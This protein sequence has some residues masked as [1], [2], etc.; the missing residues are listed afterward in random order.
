MLVCRYLALVAWLCALT[1]SFVAAIMLPIADIEGHLQQGPH[2][3]LDFSAACLF[4]LTTDPAI[5]LTWLSSLFLP[6]SDVFAIGDPN[7]S[8]FLAVSIA[9]GIVLLVFLVTCF[10]VSGRYGHIFTCFHKNR[11]RRVPRRNREICLLEVARIGTASRTFHTSQESADGAG[12]G[13]L[14][15]ATTPEKSVKNELKGDKND[16]ILEERTFFSVL[17]ECVSTFNQDGSVA[18]LLGSCNNTTETGSKLMINSQVLAPNHITGE[19]NDSSHVFMPR[20]GRNYPRT[21]AGS[22]TRYCSVSLGRPLRDQR[23]ACRSRDST[24]DIYAP[25]PS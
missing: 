12:Y 9:G 22:A 20:I 24:V 5:A 14:R 8:T 25:E 15:I 16:V 7:Q 3:L 18:F 2:L 4:Y 11:G 13:F 10:V 17:A 1:R 19:Q 21:S 23:W 6:P